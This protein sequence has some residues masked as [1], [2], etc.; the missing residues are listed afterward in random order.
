MKSTFYVEKKEEEIHETS[1][2]FDRLKIE[3]Y[4]SNS[5]CTQREIQKL[6]SDG[7]IGHLRRISYLNYL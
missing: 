7:F 5:K 6:M 3:S 2:D 4:S 1:M